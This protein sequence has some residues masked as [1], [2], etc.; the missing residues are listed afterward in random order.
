MSSSSPSSPPQRIRVVAAVVVAK[1]GR[2]LITQRRATAVLP[3]LWEFPGGRVEP[4]ERDGD[5][6]RREVMH[7]LG[8]NVRVGNLIS[9]VTHPY[10]RYTVD[11]HLY[12]CSIIAGEPFEQNVLAFR[13]VTSDEF[14]QYPFTPADEAS[15]SKLL[16]V[17]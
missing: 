1:D 7:R 3:L 5:A 6:L 14:D 15:M 17:D 9:F 4:E 2:Y 13:W 11:L 16:G 10:E 8:V 12:E